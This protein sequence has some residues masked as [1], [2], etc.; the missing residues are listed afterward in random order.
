MK[1][2]VLIFS[3]LINFS[4]AFSQKNND[5]IINK[6]F[7]TVNFVENF[8]YA[9]IG[10]SGLVYFDNTPFCLY[11]DAKFG[12]GKSPKGVDYTGTLNSN[13]FDDTYKGEIEDGYFI[14]D[15]GIGLKLNKKKNLIFYTGI[16]Q[17]SK[18]IYQQ[19]YDDLK[20]LS[21]T[22]YYY[23]E[24]KNKSILKTKFTLGIVFI[25]K[26]NITYQL[27]YDSF[28]SGINIGMGYSL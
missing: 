1:R 4:F 28:P 11:M 15:I 20:I 14:Y 6:H 9:P 12:F 22:G 3:C 27:G 24:D 25:S 10:I 21:S 13:I 5:S 26:T 16:G 17:A 7:L 18:S 23:I 19:Y 8:P 2:L